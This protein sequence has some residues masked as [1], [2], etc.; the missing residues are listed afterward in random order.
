VTGN[1]HSIRRR[2]LT[3]NVFSE[4][5]KIFRFNYRRRDMKK[6]L[7][8]LAVLIVIAT[9]AF[10]QSFDPDI[11]TGTVLPFAHKPAEPQNDKITVRRNGLSAFAT[12]PRTFSAFNPNDP[13][14]AG[15][16][17]LGYNEMLLNY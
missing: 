4:P 15:G 10:A 3:L 16:G 5:E 2:K 7:T 8:S 12:V 1:G 17:S 13:T 6:F 11:G 14:L 9:P